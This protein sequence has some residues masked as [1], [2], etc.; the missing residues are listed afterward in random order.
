M[1]AERLSEAVARPFDRVAAF[2][3]DI[4]EERAC[5]ERRCVRREERDIRL[6]QE[7][8]LTAALADATGPR[9]THSHS[10]IGQKSVTM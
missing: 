3:R 2:E 9:L 7:D 10:A 6:E 4:D 5:V 1:A 8:R